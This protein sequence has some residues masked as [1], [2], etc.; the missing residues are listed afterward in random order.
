[1]KQL[2]IFLASVALSLTALVPAIAMAD[3]DEL[4]VTMEV[5]DSMA[6]FDGQVIVMEGPEHDGLEGSDDEGESD[7]H[8]GDD[9]E[10]DF[11]VDESGD[12]FMHDEN[13]ESDEDQEHSEDESDFDEG[14]EIDTD[15]PEEDEPM[16]DEFDGLE[17]NQTAFDDDM[18]DDEAD[19]GLDDD[20]VDDIADNDSA[21]EDAADGENPD[22]A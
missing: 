10:E 5:L 16:H 11:G 20:M 12:D 6:D 9:T 7:E 18:V 13:F 14:D 22:I 1:M 21:G 19:A 8:D 4:D 3:L 15:E 2:K 17:G